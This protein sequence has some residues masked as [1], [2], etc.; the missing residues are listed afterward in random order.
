[1]VNKRN[2]AVMSEARQERMELKPPEQAAAKRVASSRLQESMGDYGTLSRRLPGPAPD[3][4]AKADTDRQ[5]HMQIHS[6]ARHR[7]V[8]SSMRTRL[9]AMI[10]CVPLLLLFR[11][12]DAEALFDAHMHYNAADADHFTPQQIIEIMDRND[13]SQ[14]AVTSNPPRLAK[15]LYEASPGRILPLLGVYREAG[16]K[17]HWPADPGLP[18]RIEAELAKGGWRGIGEL[19]LFA[20]DRHSPVFRRIVELAG[21]YALPLMLH[22]DPAVID[23]LYDIA[24]GQ[25]VIWA[26]AGTFPCPA[27]VADYLRRYPGLFVDLSVRDERIAPGGE[28][29]DEWFELFLAYPDRFMIGIDTFSLSRW[30]EYAEVA[31]RI[32]RWTRQLPD[33][34]ATRLRQGNAA[35]FFHRPLQDERE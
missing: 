16:D 25:P 11:G 31:E 23:T 34:I 19:H 30:R 14:A 24:P 9:S 3:S 29:Q 35:A 1:M 5:M 18:G 4:I 22:T 17:Q 2:G 13:I 33:D 20:D 8:I 6:P 15:R 32:R 10:L 7:P 28:L 21:E 12:L 26:H 27:L